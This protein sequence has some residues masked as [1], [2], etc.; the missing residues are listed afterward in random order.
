MGIR[1]GMS[2]EAFATAVCEGLRKAN[3]HAVLTGGAVV[4]IYSRN[5]FRSP[6]ADFVSPSDDGRIE[7]AMTR[8]GFKKKGKAFAH[9]KVKFTVAFSGRSIEIGGS[10]VREW[11]TRVGR[12]GTLHLLRPAECVMD[13]LADHF[14]V[15]GSRSREQAVWI[16]KK[17]KVDLVPV[18]RWATG[19]GH[20]EDYREFARMLR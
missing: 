4:A 11:D 1:A 9:S 6:G 14:T 12:D 16:A 19:A 18:E 15:K 3:V 5:K 10:I 8:M 2:M 17:Q 7:D 20:E 13:R